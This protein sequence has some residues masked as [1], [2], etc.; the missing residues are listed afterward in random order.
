MCDIAVALPDSTR[1]G[2]VLFAKNSD[3]PAREC[4]VLC[5]SPPRQSGSGDLIRCSYRS[6]PD[7]PLSLATVGTRPYWSWGYETGINEAGV[8]GGNTAVFT[9]PLHDEANRREP[10]L[11][12][13]E[14]LRL[15]LERAT[16]AEGAVQIITGLL[17][18]HGQWG[19]AVRG[20]SHA[21][22]SYDNAFL[23]AD[24]REAWILETAGR[25]WVADRVMAGTR[26]LSNQLTIRD[27]SSLSAPGLVEAARSAGWWSGTDEA[28]DFALAYSDHEH[29]SRQVSHLR[30]RRSAS[31]MEDRAPHIDAAFMMRL[32]RDHYE[33]TFIGEPQ[34]GPY[35]PDFQTLCMH[36]SPAGFTWGNTATSVIVE[37]DPNGER[38]PRAWF[39]YLPPCTT[40][41]LPFVPFLDELPEA[42]CRVGSAGLRVVDPTS[43]LADGPAAGSLWWRLHLL[44]EAAARNPELRDRIRRALD[45]LEE[46]LS[47]RFDRRPEGGLLDEGVAR[48][49]EILGRLEAGGEMRST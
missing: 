38:A 19:S 12:G 11:T 3:R 42:I 20:S 46:R 33:D 9:R 6:I 29:Y 49:S 14:L 16:T 31:L 27:R 44:V 26:S 5:H 8:V 17:E 10:G 43:A 22:G 36:E 4:Q 2:A 15:G 21:R 37:L 24:A 41:F 40:I 23:L 25:Q 47:A 45:P 1:T 7:A 30:W 48:L 39:S 35:L 18:Q 34:F 13:L 32:L 28:F